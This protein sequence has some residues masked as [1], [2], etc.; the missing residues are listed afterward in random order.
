MGVDETHQAKKESVL[1]PTYQHTIKSEH[2]H[3][4][5]GKHHLVSPYIIGILLFE[6]SIMDSE[7]FILNL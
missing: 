2:M 1:I 7:R 5:I 4:R 6:I 3:M